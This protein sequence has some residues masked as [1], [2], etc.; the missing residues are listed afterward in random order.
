M[1]D[2]YKLLNI[3]QDYQSR[4]SS[5]AKKVV[6]RR[7]E[8]VILESID[9]LRAIDE[10]LYVDAMRNIPQQSVDFVI[11]T[12]IREARINKK[13]NW[14][15]KD[16]RIL[17]YYL[18]NLHEDERAF[19][20]ALDVMKTSWKNFIFNGL[21]IYLLSNWLSSEDDYLKQVRELISA[22]LNIYDGINSRYNT[23]KQNIGYLE[24]ESGALR[25]SKLIDVRGM[26]LIESPRLIGFSPSIIS[27]P[28]FSE[29]ILKFVKNKDLINLSVIGDILQKHNL[30]RTRKL[31]MAHLIFD[32]D[33]HGNDK[34]QQDVA[35]FA[36]GFLGDISLA[37][38]WSPFKDATSEDVCILR[39]A[40]DLVVQWNNR[41]VI[42][43]F[44]EKCVK[45]P[46]RKRFWLKKS[47]SIVDFRI[48]GIEQEKYKLE[49][50][51]R[52]KDLVSKYFITSIYKQDTALILC[53]K[54][55]VFV[56]FSTVGS[57]FVYNHDN[58]CLSPI[59]QK[60]KNILKTEIFKNTYG[61]LVD[62]HGTYSY[63]YYAEGRMTHQG[64]WE[65]RLDKW[66][67]KI[68]DKSDLP[69][70]GFTPNNDDEIFVV[71]NKEPVVRYLDNIKYM[72]ASKDVPLKKGCFI[73]VN[74]DGFYVYLPNS[75][76]YAFI[77][78]LSADETPNGALFIRSSANGWFRVV[79][80]YMRQELDVF[81][82]RI[83][84]RNLI[85][86]L[87]YNQD[88]TITLKL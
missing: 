52:T 66:F 51:E 44:F 19:S 11:E 32:A 77:K 50:D 63:R 21:V 48:A 68:M 34:R 74:R 85:Y 61:K 76:R 20:Y 82:L 25:M 9:R 72:L 59:H 64:D 67:G 10:E 42:K 28:Y 39:K 29:V 87:D 4:F 31:V 24:D 81:Y 33:M 80:V 83:E 43:V 69:N 88:K 79:H 36:R 30:D 6:N 84:K 18:A 23:L 54:N 12:V 41:N 62:K 14:S 70:I 16:L 56:E 86:K 5:L 35:K 17:S 55:K 65:H 26:N 27:L 8:N 40:K 53:I 15:N 45:D 7:T 75:M 49:K 47:S 22:K 37:S 1:N 73:V 58:P 57:L 2:I 13:R 60:R 46:V 71:K 3:D 38:S 78:P